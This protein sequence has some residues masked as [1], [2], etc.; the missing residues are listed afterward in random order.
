MRSI[1][2]TGTFL[3]SKNLNLAQRISGL[4]GVIEGCDVVA[5]DK[6]LTISEGILKFEDGT[7]VSFE[8]NEIIDISNK[9][10]DYYYVVVIKYSEYSLAYDIVKE[11]PDYPYIKLADVTI[12]SNSVDID[13][14]FKSNAKIESATLDYSYLKDYLLASGSSED[15]IDTDE[16]GILKFNLNGSEG[17]SSFVSKKYTVGF[18]AKT[19]V[20]KISIKGNLSGNNQIS[21]GLKINDNIVVPPNNRANSMNLVASANGDTDFILNIPNGAIKKDNRCLLEMN[22]FNTTEPTTSATIYNITLN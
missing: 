5:K 7:I 2:K 22:L 12:T 3:T 18:I 14:V 16:Y 1:F 9:P 11:L 6:A 20:S 21:F 15:S 10:N 19:S 8:G 17:G 13:N 4:V